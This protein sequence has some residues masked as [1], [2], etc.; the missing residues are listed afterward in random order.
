MLAHTYD[1]VEDTVVWGI[2]IKEIPGLIR[3]LEAIPGLEADK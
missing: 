3:E 2:V 1:H